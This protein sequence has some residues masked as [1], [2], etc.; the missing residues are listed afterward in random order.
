M[1]T[2]SVMKYLGRERRRREGGRAEEKDELN[3]SKDRIL[4]LKINKCKR[5]IKF[6]FFP[7]T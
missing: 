4:L 3:I 1:Y 6:K 5:R 2:F 7:E